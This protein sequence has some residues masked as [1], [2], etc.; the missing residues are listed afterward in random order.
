MR[1]TVQPADPTV[2]ASPSPPSVRRPP[3]DVVFAVVFLTAVLAATIA[4]ISLNRQFTWDEA[5]YASKARSL[6]TAIPASHWLI[7]R[8]PGLPYLALVAAPF[9]YSETTLRVV[10]AV[11][12]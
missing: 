10:S 9:G 6:A 12:G 2:A 5:V 11:A 8:P 1:L 7:Y 3:V 4:G